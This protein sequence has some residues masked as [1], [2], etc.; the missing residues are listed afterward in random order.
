MS[1][2][3]C[4]SQGIFPCLE[5][6][7]IFARSFLKPLALADVVQVVSMCNTQDL[8]NLAWALVQLGMAPRPRL[9]ELIGE[10]LVAR[11]DACLPQ[12]LATGMWALGKWRTR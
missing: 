3:L 2:Q 6:I 4:C 9:A 7:G 8:S 1:V 5:T 12:H 10:R 11:A